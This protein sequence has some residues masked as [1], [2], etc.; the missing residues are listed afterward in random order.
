MTRAAAPNHYNTMKAN[1]I[2]LAPLATTARY[3][4]PSKRKDE[5]KQPTAEDFASDI[6]F[7][8]LAQMKPAASGATWN[9]LRNRLTKTN[10]SINFKQVLEDSIQR[11]ADAEFRRENLT[12]PFLMTTK[13]REANGWTAILPFDREERKRRNAVSYPKKNDDWLDDVVPGEFPTQSQRYFGA[14][15]F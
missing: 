5:I 1:G 14:M 10:P 15:R 2:K 4:P 6:T 7:P 9:E 13:E 11:D 3:T 12:D 8:T